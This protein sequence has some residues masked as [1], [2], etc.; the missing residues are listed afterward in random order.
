MDPMSLISIGSSLLGA[1]GSGDSKQQQSSVHQPW[2][3][4]QSW[5]TSNLGLGQQL[6][7]QYMAQPFS[8]A[9][10]QAYANSFNITG[11]G[12]GLGMGMLGSLSNSVFDRTNP[13]ARPEAPSS[14]LL[15][16]TTGSAPS[17]NA[18]G[19]GDLNQYI[20][21]GSNVA[22][23]PSKDSPE[24]QMLLARFPSYFHEAIRTSNYKP[25]DSVW[26]SNPGY[27]MSNGGVRNPYYPDDK[28]A[29]PNIPWFNPNKDG[30]P[31]FDKGNN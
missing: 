12:R 4:A 28:S 7:N 31:M 1:L 17:G 20:P 14:G 21:T 9:Q 10:Q 18:S 24:M 8:P 19:L 6:Q 16:G 22:P 29:N 3:P 25:S 2:G 5:L 23:A 11:L 30:N 27:A 13:L 15:G 26:L